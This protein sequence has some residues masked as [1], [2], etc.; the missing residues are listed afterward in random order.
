MLSAACGSSTRFTLTKRPSVTAVSSICLRR[1]GSSSVGRWSTGLSTVVA[2]RSQQSRSPIF[3]CRNFSILHDLVLWRQRPFKEKVGQ[4]LRMIRLP[5]IAY[6]IYTIG[7]RQGVVHSHQNPHKFQEQLMNSILEDSVPG[8]V[9]CQDID[10]EILS[11]ADLV[12][13]NSAA[14]S[15]DR[16][17]QVACVAQQIIQIGRKH[18]DIEIEK[19]KETVR[20]NFV[21]SAN[22]ETEEEMELL[23]EQL[24]GLYD[25]DHDVKFWTEAKSRMDGDELNVEPW[26]FIFVGG[27]ASPNA[28]VTELLP[29]RVFIT[30]SLLDFVQ[31]V[32]EMAFILGHEISHLMLGHLSA[33]GDIEYVLK[34]S[35]IVLLSLDPTA[36]LVTFAVVFLVD[37]LRRGIAM[38][39]SRDHEREADLLGIKL[40]AQCDGQYDLE[41]GARFMHRLYQQTQSDLLPLLSSHPPSLERARQ[42]YSKSLELRTANNKTE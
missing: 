6:G 28:W 3:S 19:A 8:P 7:Y 35:E 1:L 4:Y 38:V 29:K 30:K 11:E 31:N 24:E 26:R 16:Y 32:D 22:A 12:G 37:L 42:L 36:G 25:K 34:T 41:A 40:V 15:K 23:Q 21:K 9:K 18:I 39:F 10:V 5:F 17:H 33:S 20:T 27:G 2:R 14:A 13:K